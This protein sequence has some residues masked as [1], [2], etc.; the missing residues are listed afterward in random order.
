MNSVIST[1]RPLI[2]TT[3]ISADPDVNS[4]MLN[5]LLATVNEPR[6]RWISPGMTG[7][8]NWLLTSKFLGFDDDNYLM[9]GLTR[10]ESLLFLAG[11]IAGLA[12]VGSLINWLFL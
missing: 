8:F 5:E 3:T 2:S 9:Y 7:S 1:T 10:S 4:Q 6:L 11:T 12:T